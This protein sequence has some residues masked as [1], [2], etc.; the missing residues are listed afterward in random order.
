MGLALLDGW[1]DTVG[2]VVGVLWMNVGG[3][4]VR[5]KDCKYF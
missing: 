1:L 5:N 2:E 3:M 4:R